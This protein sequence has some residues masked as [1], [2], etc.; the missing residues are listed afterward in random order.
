MIFADI[1]GQ[2]STVRALSNAIQSGKIMHAYLF[3][4]PRGT[5]KTSSARIFAKSLNCVNGPTVTPC[6]KCSGCLDVV[7]ST[8]VDVIEIDAAS[9]RSVDD[10]RNILDK[11][12]YAPLHGKYKIYIIDEVHMLTNEASN[13]LLK[14][15]EEPPE[16]VIFILATTESHKVLETIVSRCQRYDFRRI[17]TDDI[18]KRL[19][20]ISKSENIN[21]TDEALLAIAKNAAGGMRDAVALLDQLSVL[22][23]NGEITVND[24]N[25]ILGQISY[26][27]IYEIAECILSSNTEKALQIL[28][29]INDRGNEPNRVL[30]ALIQYFRDMLI[31][32]SCSDKSLVMSMTKINEAIFDKIKLQGEKFDKQTLI[33]IEER[34][35]FH[36][37]KLKENTNKYMWAELCIIDLTSIEKI[38][39]VAELTEKVARLEAI[40]ENNSMPIVSKKENVSIQ[41]RETFTPIEHIKPTFAKEKATSSTTKNSEEQNITNNIPLKQNQEITDKKQDDMFADWAQICAEIKPPVNFFFKS[42]AKPVEISRNKIV[43][44]FSQEEAQKKA[45]EENRKSKLQ[46]AACKY[47]DVPNIQIICQVGGISV[48]EK[49]TEKFAEN[50][51]KQI[52]QKK[53]NEKPKFVIPQK[54]EIEPIFETEPDYNSCPDIPETT[55]DNNNSNNNDIV[56]E[57]DEQDEINTTI[58][59]EIPITTEN[60]M[61]KAEPSILYEIS[62]T[63]QNIID[64]FDGKIIH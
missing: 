30:T 48:E 17:T 42:I 20:F 39:T 61:Q 12:Q 22:G 59:N 13:A 9:N 51:E 47:F 1:T 64:L 34:L 11:V 4:G 19:K 15:L 16:N 24:V 44:S 58:E 3:C 10:A 36:F 60:N 37:S 23:Q 28:N 38:A 56:S 2:E 27:E 35:A 31:L 25:E 6:G 50:I 26:D 29:S 32:N 54:V 7:N 55:S 14:T 18:V 63:A 41:N 62:D 40:L 53:I 5:G 45:S 8:P 21:I 43:L 46:E 52:E 49:K 33:F 57:D